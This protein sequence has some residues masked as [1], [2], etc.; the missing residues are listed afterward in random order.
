MDVVTLTIPI[1]VRKKS[2]WIEKPPFPLCLKENPAVDIDTPGRTCALHRRPHDQDYLRHWR[3]F[4]R[5]VP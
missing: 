1:L 3:K 2:V 4:E 5:F